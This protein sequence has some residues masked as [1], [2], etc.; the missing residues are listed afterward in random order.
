M[1]KFLFALIFG[2]ASVPAFA[3]VSLPVEKIDTFAITTTSQLILTGKFGT[4]VAPFANC[5]IST[6][7]AMRDPNIHFS[8]RYVKPARTVLVYDRTNRRNT[9]KCSIISLH[10]LDK[11]YLAQR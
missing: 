3:E 9:V 11:I 6:I 2:L 1:K 10:Q 8:R 4:V 5:P 7:S